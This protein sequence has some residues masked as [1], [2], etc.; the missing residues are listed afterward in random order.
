MA[1][2]RTLAQANIYAL[3]IEKITGQKPEIVSFD[4]Y[5]KLLFTPDQV[6]AL[7]AYLDQQIKGAI[8]PQL[9]PPSGVIIDIMPIAGPVMLKKALPLI[10]GIAILGFLAGKVL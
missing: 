5:V 3:A 9:G 2:I 8:K 4:T 6:I 7:Q 10:A 1:N